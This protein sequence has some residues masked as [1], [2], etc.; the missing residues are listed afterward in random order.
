MK[1]SLFILAM[2]LAP[3][4]GFSQGFFDKFEDEKDV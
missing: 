4:V 2:L 1:K 3:M